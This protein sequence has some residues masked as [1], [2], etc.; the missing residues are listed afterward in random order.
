MKDSNEVATAVVPH[1]AKKIASQRTRRPGYNSVN[2]KVR[3]IF[4]RYRSS[5]ELRDFLSNTQ[6]YS[7]NIDEDII[8]FRRA[9]NVDNVC[10]GRENDKSE[11]F[12][13]FLCLFF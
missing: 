1:R 11:F 13:L 3:E 4:S 5:D 7:S 8:S 2:S 6:I 12:Y 9:R 10:H